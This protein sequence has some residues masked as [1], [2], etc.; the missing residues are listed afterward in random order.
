MEAFMTYKM[1][2]QNLI[3]NKVV[4][5]TTILFIAD[6]IQDNDVSVQSGH[7][8]F[9]LD[10]DNQPVNPAPGQLYVPVC[11]LRDGTAKTGDNAF[12]GGQHFTVA[13]F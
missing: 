9:L 13:G 11:Y 4:S 6:N 3:G 7:F 12:I 8:D 1:V 2:R 10:L 5:L